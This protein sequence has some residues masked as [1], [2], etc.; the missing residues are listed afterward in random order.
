MP[1]TEPAYQVNDNQSPLLPDVIDTHANGSKRRLM[2]PLIKA[3]HASCGAPWCSQ[4]ALTQPICI[5][6]ACMPLVQHTSSDCTWDATLVRLLLLLLL[7][8]LLLL[9]LLLP[10]PP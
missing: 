7:L 10:L 3:A 4:G 9:T 8:M 1:E 2:W 5:A 6:A